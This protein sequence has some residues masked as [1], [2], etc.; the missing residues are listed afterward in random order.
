[1]SVN[2]VYF[3]IGEFDILYARFTFFNWSPFPVLSLLLVPCKLV[4]EAMTWT[5]R[6]LLWR[7]ALSLRALWSLMLPEKAER[8]FSWSLGQLCIALD[9]DRCMPLHTDVST[10]H[11]C[12]LHNWQIVLDIVDD[13]LPL[14]L[15]LPKS[16][17]SFAEHWFLLL[18]NPC[19]I[20]FQWGAVDKKR[21]YMTT[22]FLMWSDN[23]FETNLVRFSFRRDLC[24]WGKVASSGLDLFRF[25]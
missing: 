2:V 4:Y 15:L 3:C 1:M 6:M 9:H 17:A 7:L 11:H 24:V 21:Y 20:H 22:I 8:I 5:F 10:W 16:T 25:L 13:V 18:S 23:R 14:P 19:K 12:D